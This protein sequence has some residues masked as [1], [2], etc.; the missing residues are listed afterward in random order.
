MLVND[1]M[2]SRRNP[3][4]NIRTSAYDSF[5]R[6]AHT[7]DMFITFSSLPK[8]GVNPQ[9]GWMTPIGIY[10]YPLE[11]AIKMA[12]QK[13]QAR[14]Q[15]TNFFD[16]LPFASLRDYII[17]FQFRG[18]AIRSSR[19]TTNDLEEDLLEVEDALVAEYGM[20]QT[21][22]DN[23][24]ERI[25]D[26]VSSHVPLVILMESIYLFMKY[27]GVSSGKRSIISRSILYKTLGYDAVIDDAGVGALHEDESTQAVFFSTKNLSLVSIEENKIPK[28]KV[29]KD[30]PNFDEDDLD[31]MGV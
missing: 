26:D 19:Y 27:D 28:P 6:Y 11:Y 24:H 23:A 14:G 5:S 15:H 18:N 21:F 3:E 29:D 30:I 12:E 31:Y 10:G 22:V 20:T 8:L 2:E 17:L 9:S 1:L 4:T 7:G 16:K 25:W 13:S